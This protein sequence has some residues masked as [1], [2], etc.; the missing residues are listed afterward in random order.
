MILS[1]PGLRRRGMGPV[2]RMSVT[3]GCVTCGNVAAGSV[4]GVHAAR[5]AQVTG[6]NVEMQTSVSRP[7]GAVTANPREQQQ[8]H[9]YHKRKRVD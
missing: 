2:S 3:G 6:M 5:A 4:H 1:A 8:S 7:V 9:C